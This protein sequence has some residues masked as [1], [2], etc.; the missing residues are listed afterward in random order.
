MRGVPPPLIL[1][2]ELDLERIASHVERSLMLVTALTPAIGYEKAAL[3]A[4]TAHVE[5]TTLREANRKLGFLAEADFDR[6][7][8]PE[9]MV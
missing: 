9:T 3:L 6:L 1:G 8:R 2:I 4:R 7:L 5:K